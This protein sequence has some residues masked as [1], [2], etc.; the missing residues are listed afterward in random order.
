VKIAW[1]YKAN[2]FKSATNAQIF[3]QI[4]V[5]LSKGSIIFEA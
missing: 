3:L 5:Q 2:I 1:R 4:V